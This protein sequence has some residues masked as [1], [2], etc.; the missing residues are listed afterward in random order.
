[1]ARKALSCGTNDRLFSI[2]KEATRCYSEEIA[3]DIT[4]IRL[5]Y[6]VPL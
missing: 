5:I 2:V 1:M 4:E 6:L 3:R